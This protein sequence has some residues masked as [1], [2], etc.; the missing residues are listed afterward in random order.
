MEK[1]NPGSDTW[2]SKASMMKSLTTHKAVKS[3]TKVYISGGA[4]HDSWYIKDT[5][6][7]DCILDTWTRGSDLNQARAYHIMSIVDG[8]IHVMGGFCDDGVAYNVEF[9][10]ST[11]G[12]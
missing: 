6:I 3:G 9:M 5:Y 1:Y 10:D 12:I 8:K 4:S 2:S 7:Y 11:S